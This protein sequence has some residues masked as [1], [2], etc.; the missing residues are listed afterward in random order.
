[1]SEK[2]LKLFKSFDFYYGLIAVLIAAIFF[3]TSDLFAGQAA[4]QAV[5]YSGSRGILIPNESL[6]A[7]YRKERTEILRNLTKSKNPHLLKQ[8]LK[9]ING[10]ISYLEDVIKRNRALPEAPT[11][12]KKA[13][14]KRPLA[15]KKS[16]PPVKMKLAV[17][18]AASISK[19][20]PTAAKTSPITPLMNQKIIPSLQ[21]QNRLSA[22]AHHAPPVRRP[23]QLVIPRALEPKKIDPVTIP[24][25]SKPLVIN[26][27]KPPQTA[28]VK[29]VS[30]AMPVVPSVIPS[31]TTFQTPRA[32]VS[33]NV[34][35]PAVS[36]IQ[37]PKLDSQAKSVP[38][39]PSFKIQSIP[40]QQLIETKKP[41]TTP[42]ID[43]AA[44][45]PKASQ[46]SKAVSSP[47]SKI[48]VESPQIERGS[49]AHKGKKGS[50][51]I[52]MTK[53]EKEMYVFS[54]MGALVKQ[55]VVCMKPSYFY[56]HSLDAS[57]EKNQ[58]LKDHNL[59]DLFIASVYDNESDARNAIDKIRR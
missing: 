29:A 50:D 23:A 13:A 37:V 12:A 41:N 58:A 22:E 49:K 47:P 42:P 46:V 27:F 8:K 38:A 2:D 14:A 44:L 52:E 40:V 5:N 56:I 31:V 16:S 53:E 54:A 11:P 9:I 26:F 48:G 17:P 21:S 10:K 39:S 59:D 30:A 51:W 7:D 4:R 35:K 3:I 43:V 34:L 18:H 32:P 55:D 45:M 24:E 28:P 20:E 19:T 36:S 57:F 1:M 25:S 6:L 15:S 33:L